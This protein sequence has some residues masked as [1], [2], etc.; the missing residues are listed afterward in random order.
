[1][2]V[3]DNFVFIHLPRSGGTFVSDIIKKFFPSTREIGYHF[4]RQLLPSEYSH[5]PILGTVRNPWEFYP[6]WYEHQSAKPVYLPSKHVLFG[7]LSQHRTLDFERTVRNALS[8]GVSDE[9]LDALIDAL[10]ENFDYEAR[11]ISNI[12][13]DTMAKIRGTGLGLYAFRFNVMFGEAAD[14]FFCRLE[15]LRIDLTTFFEKIGVAT[16]EMRSYV[17]NLDKKNTSEHNHYSSYY[18]PELAELVSI[19]EHQLIERFGFTFEGHAGRR[20]QKRTRRPIPAL[21]SVDES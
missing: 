14:V 11:S 19:R 16:D 9:K 21:A 10:P 13:K 3:N 5:L 20:P 4:P 1:M 7:Y 2:L 12:T 15:S 18:T 17:F 6:S 8:L